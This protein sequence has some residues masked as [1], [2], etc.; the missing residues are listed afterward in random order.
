MNAGTCSSRSYIQPQG[1]PAVERALNFLELSASSNVGFTLSEVGEALGIAKSSSHRFG[2][3]ERRVYPLRGGRSAR[4]C[5]EQLPP[6]YIHFAIP[7]ISAENSKRAPLHPW[8]EGSRLGKYHRRGSS[9][10]SVVCPIR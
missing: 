4:N 8:D 3:L 2:L 10:G 1:I 6:P 7:R 9:V 5:E